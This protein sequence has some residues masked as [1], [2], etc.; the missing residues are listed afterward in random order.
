MKDIGK[1]S[2]LAVAQDRATVSH[3]ELSKRLCSRQEAIYRPSV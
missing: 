2:G 3:S 1:S